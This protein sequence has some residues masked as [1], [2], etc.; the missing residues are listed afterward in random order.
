LKTSRVPSEIVIPII[1]RYL[2][3]YETFGDHTGGWNQSRGVTKLSAA[4]ILAENAGIKP[5][6][7]AKYMKGL[8]QYLSFYVVDRLLSAMD[9]PMRWYE[10]PLLPYYL[11]AD[12]SEPPPGYRVCAR[13]DC[14]RE[15]RVTQSNHRYCTKYCQR[16]SMRKRWKMR[17]AEKVKQY[18]AAW[19]RS[20]REKYPGKSKT[21]EARALHAKHCR[22]YRARQKVAA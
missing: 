9:Q 20:Y 1:Q 16:Y 6:T 10:W 11:A 3:S 17:N 13:E 19:M 22:D 5:D 12:L 18:H 2:D 7:L 4:T 14:E 8:T 15:Y 21:P